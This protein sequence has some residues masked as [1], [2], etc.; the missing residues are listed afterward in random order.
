MEGLTFIR[1]LLSSQH[2]PYHLVGISSSKFHNRGTERASNLS[3]VR[4]PGLGPGSLAAGLEPYSPPQP[5]HPPIPEAPALG[6]AQAPGPL[7]LPTPIQSGSSP[8]APTRPT[9]LLGQERD[10][11]STD[12]TEALHDL[13]LAGSNWEEAWKGSPCGSPRFEPW[14]GP[15]PSGAA[16]QRVAL[17]GR[18]L[19]CDR[20]TDMHLVFAPH[21]WHLGLLT[22]EV[23]GASLLIYT[24]FSTTPE[25]IRG[26]ELLAKSPELQGA[27]AG[28]R[29]SQPAMR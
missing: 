19:G 14:L 28:W 20:L 9:H 10:N 17:G 3:K 4:E 23:G 2:R 15:I 6:D 21:S 25:F 29:L 16:A 22:D 12:A 24:L 1:R 18:V 11:L 27:E 8:P 13:S 26:L 5:P 7:T